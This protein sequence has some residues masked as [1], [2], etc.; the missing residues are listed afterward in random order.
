MFYMA[1]GCIAE[2]RIALMRVGSSFVEAKTN[3]EFPKFF[4][5]KYVEELRIIVL[6]RKTIFIFTNSAEPERRCKRGHRKSIPIA[7]TPA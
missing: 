7:T 2:E 3:S 1:C 4:F 5:H 6:S